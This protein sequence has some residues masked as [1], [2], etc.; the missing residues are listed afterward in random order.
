MGEA[1]R[2]WWGWATEYPEDGY[3]AVDAASR[4]E[5]Q[6]KVRKLLS[7]DDDPDNPMKTSVRRVT[8][9]DVDDLQDALARGE[10]Q[11]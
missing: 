3:I 2:P 9:K 11:G 6:A 7:A 10:G 8:A 1:K 5:A 4:A